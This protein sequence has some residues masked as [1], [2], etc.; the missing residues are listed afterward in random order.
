MSDVIRGRYAPTPPQPYPGNAETF[1]GVYSWNM[2]QAAINP[3]DVIITPPVSALAQWIRM[4]IEERKAAEQREIAIARSSL[5]ERDRVRLA[6]RDYLIAEAE[7]REW[8]QQDDIARNKE[9]QRTASLNPDADLL[10][11]LH[12]IPRH[13]RQPLLLRLDFFRKQQIAA[14][15]DGK[16]DKPANAFMHSIIKRALPRLEQVNNRNL[17]AAYRYI[18]GRERLDELLRLPELNKREV[19]LVATLTAGAME[20]LFSRLCDQHFINGPTPEAALRVYQLVAGEALRLNVVPP[21]WLALDASRRKRGKIPYHLLPGALA[22]LCCATWW[23]RRLWRS[24]CEWREEQFRAICQVGVNTSAFVSYD[25]LTHKREQR[26]LTREFIKNH[27]LVNDDGVRLDMEDVYYAGNSNPQHRRFEMMATMKGLENVAELRADSAVWCTITCPS[28][29]HATLKNGKP[30]PKWTTRTVRDSSDYLVDMFSGVRK[31]LNRKGLRWYG[32][33]VAE[34][35]HDGTVHWH[36]MIFT[37]PDEREDVISILREF[38]IREDRAELGNDITPRF[39]EEL[40][41]KDKGSPCS[42]IAAYI[43]KNL[44]GAPLRKPDPKTGQVRLDHESGKNMADTVEH[45]VA[46]ASLHRVRQFQFFGIPS[47]QTYRELRLLAGQMSRIGITGKKKR[48]LTDKAM[49]DVLSAADAGC[50]AT[51]IL[52]QG[53]VLSPRCDHVVRTA[54][55]EADKLN[56]YGEINMQIYGVWSP[57]LG[58]ESRICTHT[59]N[60]QLVRKSKSATGEA[61]RPGLDLDRQGGPSAPWTRGNNCPT[62]QNVITETGGIATSA[63][64]E[65][66]NFDVMPK[67][68]RRAMLHRLRQET[69][70]PVPESSQNS[71][72]DVSAAQDSP[73]IA[74]LSQAIGIKLTAWEAHALLNGATLDMG[75]GEGIQLRDGRLATVRMR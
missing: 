56:D 75:E 37:R 62:G 44:D 12:L 67:K 11:S 60:W 29:Y 39:K 9:A 27:E 50:I 30:N 46:W 5:T 34:P 57:Q 8:Q 41:T 13:L 24:R 22:R 64:Q 21:Q 36:M 40:I 23:Q 61:D 55:H 25:A 32:I 59:D 6:R 47:R 26:R 18:A 2:P 51:Y 72:V 45:A 65:T 4:D 1:T 3:A 58:D 53:G 7:E 66:I 74:R 63:E 48:R 52:K 35:H 69:P 14:E 19:K 71:A 49:D 42:Y 16:S 28:K 15:L 20:M 70:N 31:K 73:D 68:E 54:Y 10:A 43:G 17:T 38:A 33:R